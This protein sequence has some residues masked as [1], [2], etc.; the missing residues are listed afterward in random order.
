[1]TRAPRLVQVVHGGRPDRARGP[2]EAQ[3]GLGG[4]RDAL[5]PALGPA[6]RGTAGALLPARPARGGVRPGGAL[7]GGEPGRAQGHQLRVRRSLPGRRPRPGG[8]DRARVGAARPRRRH[9]LPGALD[10]VEPR[11]RRAGRQRRDAARFDLGAAAARGAS[12]SAEAPQL[13]LRVFAGPRPADALRRFTAATGR[14]PAAPAPWAFGPVVPDRPAEHRAAGRARR[15]SWTRCAGPT[16]RCRRPRRRCTTCP[17]A[18]TAARGLRGARARASSTRQGLAH[19]HLLQP[20]AVRVVPA[21]ST[22]ARGRRGAARSDGAGAAVHVHSLRR[23][24]RGPAGFTVEPLAAVRL[25]RAAGA[26]RST[27]GCSSEA[28]ARRPRRLDGGLRRVHAARRRRRRRHAR[29]ARCTTATRRDYHCAACAFARPPRAA[30]RALPALGLDGRRALRRRS[31]GAATRRP[32]WASTACSSARHAGARASGCRASA[33]GA[34]TSA[35]TTRSATTRGSR[36][37]CSSAGSSSARV[38]GVMRTKAIGHRDPAPTRARRSGTRTS[39][40]VVAP[41]REAAHAAL[42]VPR[43]RRRAAT[44]RP[45]C[46]SCATLA[47]AY[48]GDPRAR[49]ARTSSCFGADLLAAPV[50]QPR[51]A[52]AQRATCRAGAGSTRGARSR[53]DA[54]RRRPRLRPRA[55]AARRPRPS[56]LPGAARRAAAVRAR[57]R[58]DA[59]AARRRR[60]ARRPYGGPAV[61]RLADRARPAA[62]CSP[63]R[64]GAAAPAW[65]RGASGSCPP[66]AGTP[67]RSRCGKASRRYR[68]QAA[69]SGL[70]HPFA[71]SRVT[72]N[73]RRLAASRVELPRPVEGLRPAFRIRSGTLRASGAAALHRSAS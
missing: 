69:L 8:S 48:P 55:A 26:R 18:R 44:A 35:A 27:A 28:R 17:A 1:M 72:L 60:H 11:L 24:R 34:R 63:S 30:A 5:A 46:R 57:R 22:T 14:Q 58:G 20:D 32:T 61:V 16:R 21:A 33:A 6:R 7:D 43:G 64:A 2:C 37:S 3:S 68:L 66:R 19:A 70:R 25:H 39:M 23:R 38:S 65:A 42:S 41:L 59:A 62:A 15:A 4:T 40:P 52:H 13:E 53:Y 54:A 31:S 73:G 9:L 10:A 29:R 56:T 49:R 12:M 36:P 67:G 47:L 45:A 71:P 50:L 51:R